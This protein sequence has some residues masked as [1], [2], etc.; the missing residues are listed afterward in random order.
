MTAI[1]VVIFQPY[2]ISFTKQNNKKFSPRHDFNVGNKPNPRET[3]SKR[4]VN[5]LLTLTLN[6]TTTR[7]YTTTKATLKLTTKS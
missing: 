4:Q 7:I 2:I 5:I 1:T 3:G 6:A